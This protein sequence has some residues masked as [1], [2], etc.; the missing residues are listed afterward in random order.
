MV[1]LWLGC[2]LLSC[3]NAGAIMKAASAVVRRSCFTIAIP[4]SSRTADECSVCCCHVRTVSG[5][6]KCRHEI[7]THAF[8]VMR[9]NRLKSGGSA[10]VVLLCC[11]CHSFCTGRGPQ[12]WPERGLRTGPQRRP[13]P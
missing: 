5:E 8:A 13:N 3:A 6:R 12:D 9:E 1:G 7:G 11:C 10:Y 2:V 4:P